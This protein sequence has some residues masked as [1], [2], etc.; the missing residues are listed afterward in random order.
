MCCRKQST[1]A[2]AAATTVPIPSIVQ[3]QMS[4]QETGIMK[5]GS[6]TP[7]ATPPPY[8][9]ILNEKAMAEW[10]QETSDSEQ[11]VHPAL[12]TSSDSTISYV[13][14]TSTSGRFLQTVA[15]AFL[16]TLNRQVIQLYIALEASSAKF[17]TR[18]LL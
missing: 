3:P 2:A 16:L 1:K 6:T 13:S 18:K 7:S 5:D 4:R 8:Y 15:S 11:D 17:S 12:R 14:E 9:A 10:I